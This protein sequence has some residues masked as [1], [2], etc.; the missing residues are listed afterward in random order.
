MLIITN[1]QRNIDIIKKN[2]FSNGDIIIDEELLYKRK[3]SVAQQCDKMIDN[4]NLFMKKIEK[5]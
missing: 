5:K 4:Y 3:D 1:E 2:A